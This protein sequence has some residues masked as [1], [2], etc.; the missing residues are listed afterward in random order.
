MIENG[1]FIEWA[2]IFGNFYGTSFYNI[3]MV[4]KEKK[5]LLLVIDVQGAEQLQRLNKKGCYIFILPPSMDELKNRLFKRSLDTE[6]V[7]ASRLSK[8]PDE[9]SHYKNYDYI[10][11]NSDV[12]EAAS[13]L[14]SIVFAERCRYKN[15]LDR[16]DCVVLSCKK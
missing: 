9:I 6:N 13:Q 7:I 5:D 2:N 14:R 15:F 3:E 11:I 10:I 8:A 16:N 12:N 1:E 4:E